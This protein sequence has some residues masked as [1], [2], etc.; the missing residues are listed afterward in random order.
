MLTKQKAFNTANVELM[1]AR[2]ESQIA[3]AT[4][5]LQQLQAE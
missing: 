3:E 5:K 2:V 1:N 4:L